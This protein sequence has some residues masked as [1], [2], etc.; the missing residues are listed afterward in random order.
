MP[1]SANER[2]ELRLAIICGLSL[3]T[4]FGLSL[5]PETPS[6]LSILFYAAAYLSGGYFT[7][8]QAFRGIYARKFDIDFLMLVAAAGAAALGRLA[9]GALLLF[10][11]SLG[12]ALEHYAMGRARKSI[13]ALTDLTPKIAL[14]KSGDSVKEVKPEDLKKRDVVL[15]KPNT[16]IPVD[17]VVIAGHSNVDQA[18]ITGE[19]IPVEKFSID[20]RDL[21]LERLEQVDKKHKV[22]AGTLNGESNL[23]VL[24]TKL[25]VDSTLA[26][27]IALVN[28]AQTQKSP[29][30]HFT[31]KIQRYYV[32][33][34]L[35]LVTLLLFAFLVIDEPFG[36]SFYR[37]M[38]VLVAASPCALAISTPSAVLSGIARAARGGVLIKG[39]RALEE[40]GSLQAIAF[41]KTGTLTEGKPKL[42]GVYPLNG[43]TEDRLLETVVAVEKLS[44][45]P[46]AA[47]V[48][49]GGQQRLGFDVP[50]ASSIQSVVGRGLLAKYNG[51]TINV[52]KKELF[53]QQA[54]LFT[55]AIAD[56]LASL[57]SQ[58]NTT[59]LV[60]GA[61]KL[62]GI[63]TVM[64]VARSDARKTLDHLRSLG[65]RQIVM[66]TG[67]NQQ[68]AEAIG[69]QIGITET[70]GNLLPEQKVAVI[71]TLRKSAKNVAM[72]G[73]G[74]NDAPA[75][76]KSSIGIAMGAAGSDVALETADV[77]LMA[78]NL[79]NLTFAIALGRKANRIIRQNVVISMGMICLLIPLTLSGIAHIGPAVI[80]HEGSTVLVVLNALRLLA[81]GKSPNAGPAHPAASVRQKNQR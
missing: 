63:I 80:G 68:V 61:T 47:A 3:G 66:L 54:N 17:G 11:F 26:R 77:A 8:K 14:L 41:D 58:G 57:E 15:I 21:D 78:D 69:R 7:T 55:A 43:I 39:G 34:V 2:F 5:L 33:A 48:V 44:D 52:G 28:E 20:Q 56:K 67:D 79:S 53:E 76:A 12:H 37:A 81:F 36:K 35:I 38:S 13:A 74:V 22:F 71:E 16:K 24:V 18:S 50:A 25:A 27:L 1:N 4:G 46:L 60:G 32:P 45:H 40:L 73:D 49:K 31:D 64:D 72:V 70:Y 10:L 42:T 6:F 75:M 19:S 62:F 59:M 29:T 51:S 30:Q 23:E 9:E 65:I